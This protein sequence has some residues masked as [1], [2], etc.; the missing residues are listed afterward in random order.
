MK[1]IK[2]EKY[3]H[4]RNEKR[5]KYHKKEM[6]LHSKE[7]DLLKREYGKNLMEQKS[8]KLKIFLCHANHDKSKVR[9]LY[10]KLKHDGFDAGNVFFCI[11]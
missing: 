3:R 5:L 6:S 9:Y 4:I 10:T 8:K 11:K 7:I 1:V 2:R